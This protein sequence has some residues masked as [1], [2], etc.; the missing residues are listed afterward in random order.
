MFTSRKRKFREQMKR[1]VEKALDDVAK[2][3]P[4]VTAT[5]HTHEGSPAKVLLNACDGADLLVVG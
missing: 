5:C 1:I 2:L 3:T 4:G